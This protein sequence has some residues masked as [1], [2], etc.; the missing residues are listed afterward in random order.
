M[1]PRFLDEQS[2]ETSASPLA[3]VDK[4][5]PF[6]IAYGSDDFPHLRKQA[7]VMADTLRSAAGEVVSIELDGCD[8]L[9]A[10]YMAGE[11]DGPWVTA[12]AWIHTF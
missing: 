5:P 4:P 3:F 8:H 6:L 11:A 9:G 1:R 7:Q 10:S 12:A 2:K